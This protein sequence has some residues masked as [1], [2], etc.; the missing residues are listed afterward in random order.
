MLSD[1][2]SAGLFIVT[3]I[4]YFGALTHGYF[5]RRAF[6]KALE[7]EK[8]EEEL[9]SLVLDLPREEGRTPTQ[10]ISPDLPSKEVMR[11][12]G[13]EMRCMGMDSI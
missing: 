8:R 9:Q 7:E 5:E 11:C 1:D 13:M 4:L 3:A 2:N 10:P 6:K 12:M